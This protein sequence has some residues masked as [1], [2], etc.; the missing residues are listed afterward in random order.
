MR[1]FSHEWLWIAIVLYVISAGTATAILGP[2]VRKLIEMG[3]QGQGGSPEFMKLVGVQQ[4][5]GP[6]LSA[7]AVAIIVL[8]VWK[9][10]S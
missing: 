2:G 1:F 10:G 7:M 5:L 3:K 9:P 8:M 6:L 4:R